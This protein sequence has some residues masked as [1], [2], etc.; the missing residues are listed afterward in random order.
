[1]KKAFLIAALLCSL[2][3]GAQ[4]IYSPQK[5][6]VFSAIYLSDSHIDTCYIS[7]WTTNNH[8]EFDTKQRELCYAYHENSDNLIEKWPYQTCE[9]TGLIEDSKIIWLH[10]PRSEEFSILEY[11]PFPEI[12][13]PIKCS[14]KYK[15]AFLGHI[16]FL[17]KSGYIR[18]KMCIHCD[19]DKSEIIGN[20]HNRLGD[21]NVQYIFDNQCGFTKMEYHYNNIIIKLELVDII[22][23]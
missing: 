7:M 4:T 16:D 5:E 12:N 17:E 18:Y 19:G 13:F 20:A 3:I 22:E 1:M 6:F 14:K 23:H 2:S 15:R 8:W 11:F 10:P 21:W 9:T